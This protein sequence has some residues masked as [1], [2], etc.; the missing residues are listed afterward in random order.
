[1][2]KGD[3]GGPLTYNGKQIGI[4]SFGRGCAQDYP[5]VYTNV[6]P[7]ADW[8]KNIT[9][10]ARETSSFYVF[11]TFFIFFFATILT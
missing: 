5:G 11:L 9:S 7:Y 10:G 2:F 6:I 8:I 3:S 1:M 4:V